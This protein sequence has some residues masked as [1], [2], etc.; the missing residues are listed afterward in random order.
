V[1][2]QLAERLNALTEQNK[3]LRDARNAYLLKEAERKH[4]EAVLIQSAAGK[5]SA[6]KTVNAQASDEW[7]EFQQELAVLEGA[8]EFERLKYEILDKAWTSEYGTYKIEE[9]IIKKHG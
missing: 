9:R 3:K 8:Y 6:E 1:D 5:S 7:L 4:H 2:R